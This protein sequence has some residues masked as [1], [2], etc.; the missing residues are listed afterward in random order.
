MQNK[1]LKTTSDI[2]LKLSLVFFTVL[3]VCFFI[4]VSVFSNGFEKIA[5]L[6]TFLTI[7]SSFIIISSITRLVLIRR[8]S[9]NRTDG[10]Y[11]IIGIT[12]IIS[13]IIIVTFLLNIG[14]LNLF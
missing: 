2:G 14:G 8:S 1:K 9:E 4:P 5:Y 6:A 12:G 3:A 7:A 13:I 10:Q 11:T